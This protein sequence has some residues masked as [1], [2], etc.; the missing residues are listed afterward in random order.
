VLIGVV[1]PLVQEGFADLTK[2]SP[3]VTGP[4]AKV[5]ALRLEGDE[6]ET[7]VFPAKMDFDLRT[8]NDAYNTEWPKEQYDRWARAHGGVDD[9]AVNIKLVLEGNRPAPIRILGMRPIKHCQDPLTGTLLLSP[10]AGADSS[11]R[12]GINLDEPRPIAR[13]LQGGMALKGDYFAE[14]T[15]SLKRGE[16]QTFQITAVTVRSYCE[17]TLELTILDNGKT[18]TQEIKNGSGPF[19]VSAVKTTG[20][21][22]SP[23]IYSAYQALYVGGVATR[24]GAFVRVNPSTY[25]SG[26]TVGLTRRPPSTHLADGEP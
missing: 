20:D 13:K 19:R 12:V 10:S 5:A 6:S 17:F 23:G 24:D 21:W 25:D 3:A 1:T 4:A 2:G 26:R 9:Y 8:I 7:Y 14:K 22:G 15:V 16:Q 11:V 18:I